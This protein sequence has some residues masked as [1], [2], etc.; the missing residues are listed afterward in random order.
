MLSKLL[1]S[2]QG[3]AAVINPYKTWRLGWG[4]VALICKETLCV[5]GFLVRLVSYFSPKKSL[6]KKN[7]NLNGILDEGSTKTFTCARPLIGQYVFLQLVGV[8][9]SLSLCEVEVFTPDGKFRDIRLL[10]A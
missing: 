10:S 2:P 8:E 9:G 6:E 3:G 7:G 1:E 4:I 5:L